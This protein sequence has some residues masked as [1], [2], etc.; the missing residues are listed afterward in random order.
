MRFGQP[1]RSK[2]GWVTA[3]FESVCEICGDEVEEGDSIAFDEDNQEW[4]H[5]ECLDAEG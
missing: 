1:A 3:M 2:N 4:V 5:G